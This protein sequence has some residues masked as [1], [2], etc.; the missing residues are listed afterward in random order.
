[1]LIVQ[2][3]LAFPEGLVE[4]LPQPATASRVAI[5]R[6]DTI[7]LRITLCITRSVESQGSKVSGSALPASNARDC[8]GSDGP[9]DAGLP[10]RVW[11]AGSLATE[12]RMPPLRQIRARTR[13][14]RRVIAAA[15]LFA[16]AS[17]D[18]PR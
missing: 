10:S 8:R 4:S 16:S 12:A 1:M 2:G 9:G 17:L 11:P 14:T 7:V 13:F 5:A 18:P 6:P 3:A 15:I